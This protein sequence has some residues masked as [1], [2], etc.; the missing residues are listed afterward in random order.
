MAAS[1]DITASDYPWEAKAQARLARELSNDWLLLNNLPPEVGGR[2]IDVLALS[3]RGAIVIEL[4]EKRGTIFEVRTTG[5]WLCDGAPW[6]EGVKEV[7]PINQATRASQKLKSAFN[8][9]FPECLYKPRFDRCVLITTA[10]ATLNFVSASA[11]DLAAHIDNAT[12]LLELRI[13]IGNDKSIDDGAR[14]LTFEQLALIL[15]LCERDI[16]DQSFSANPDYAEWLRRVKDS[17]RRPE[18]ELAPP[19]QIIFPEVKFTPSGPQLVLNVNDLAAGSVL[20]FADASGKT[21]RAR[22]P[23]GT[24]MGGAFIIGGQRYLLV[25]RNAA[26]PAG[27]ANEEAGKLESDNEKKQQDA[28]RAAKQRAADAEAQR[29]RDEQAA[30]RERTRQLALEQERRLKREADQRRAR[31]QS[32]L[33]GL[34]SGLITI[35]VIG[36]LGWAAVRWLYNV[37]ED[38]LCRMSRPSTVSSPSTSNL[39]NVYRRKGYDSSVAFQVS[40]G[41]AA[42]PRDFASDDSGERWARIRFFDGRSGWI[43]TAWLGRDNSSPSE[44]PSMENERRSSPSIEHDEYETQQPNLDP[45][46]TE[47]RRPLA[48]EDRDSDRPEQ[49]PRERQNSP[50]S[51]DQADVVPAP[52]QSGVAAGVTCY[53]PSLEQVQLSRAAC[54]ARGGTFD[55]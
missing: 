31:F 17:E 48:R 29:K 44:R 5:A 50:S 28:L 54:R 38:S 11:Y 40:S 10:G 16:L 34:L 9:A 6:V 24:R 30:A 18:P 35:A 41:T 22:V 23:A 21:I 43:P 20:S 19:Q 49:R 53:L 12:A 1:I 15:R 2:E 25:D 39:V 33:K 46:R 4:K 7:N 27:S 55:E 26:Q 52:A 42:C 36:G 51:R 8:R 14:R 37:N 13:T 3:R 47:I 32:S 45:P